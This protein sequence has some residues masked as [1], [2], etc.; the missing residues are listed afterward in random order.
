MDMKLEVVVLPVADVERSKVFYGK[1][2]WRL[3]ADI[4][5]GV[6][7]RVVQFTPPASSCSIQFGTGVSTA[8]PGSVKNLYLIVTDVGAARADLSSHGAEV[9]EVYHRVPSG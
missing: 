9:G 5:R 1:L 4:T 8:S 2:G 7:F 3:D 6:D